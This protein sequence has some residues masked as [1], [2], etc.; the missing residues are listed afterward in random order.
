MVQWGR[1]ASPFRTKNPKR[2]MRRSWGLVLL[3][4]AALPILGCAKNGSECDTCAMDSDCKAG[5][6]CTNF[7][8]EN[9][10][11]AGKH[12]GTGTGATTCRVR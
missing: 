3:A 12:C 6:F 9:G 5:L 11:A 7:K 4:L 2:P 8:D 1:M 10:N